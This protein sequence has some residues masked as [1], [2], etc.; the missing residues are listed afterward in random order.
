MLLPDTKSAHIL[1]Q[2]HCAFSYGTM[3]LKES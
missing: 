2:C 3:W 1:L